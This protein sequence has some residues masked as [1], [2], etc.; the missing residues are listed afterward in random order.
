MNRLQTNLGTGFAQIKPEGMCFD[1]TEG[2]IWDPRDKAK[3]KYINSI[4][5]YRRSSA[6][7]AWDEALHANAEAL[8]DE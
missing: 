4:P 3:A 7:K 2:Y 6:S 8:H 5:K 1:Y